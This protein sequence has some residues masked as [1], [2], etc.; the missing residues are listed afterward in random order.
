[1]A[2]VYTRRDEGSLY[3]AIES[4]DLCKLD[5]V[6]RLLLRPPPSFFALWKKRRGPTPSNSSAGRSSSR[7]GPLRSN[8]KP[9]N[10]PSSLEN[11]I[12]R[13]SSC[14]SLNLFPITRSF[15]PPSSIKG[16]TISAMMRTFEGYG[17]I[18]GTDISAESVT[19]WVEL[20]A[21]SRA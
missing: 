1:M 5:V 2:R 4:N 20:R 13:R 18:D 3:H 21:A 6:S 7:S 11:L 16:G 19:A 15:S 10:L 8:P 9:R 17:G 12:A 14:A